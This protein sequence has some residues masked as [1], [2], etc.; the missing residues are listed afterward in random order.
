[1]AMV[2]ALALGAAEPATACF[3]VSPEM[4]CANCEKKIKENLRFEKGVSSVETSLAS[5]TVTVKY[6]P[7]KT[8]E[9]K[10]IDGF[11]KIGYT[12][13]IA[14]GNQTQVEKAA[15]TGGKCCRKAS[16]DCHNDCHKR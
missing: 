12:A 15:C 8:D 9:A 16:T 6:N 13:T 4:S 10:I 3:N 7:A 1:M 5:Q 2:T 14:S 11:K